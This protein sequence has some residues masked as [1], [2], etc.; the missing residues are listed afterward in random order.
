MCHEDE[1]ARTWDERPLFGAGKQRDVDRLSRAA[2]S[3][4][5]NCAGQLRSTHA[6]RG[7]GEGLTLHD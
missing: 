5:Q 7:R 6:L 1:A 2:H 3:R 4:P